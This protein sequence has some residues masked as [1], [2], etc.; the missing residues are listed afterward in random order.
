[1]AA[2]APRRQHGGDGNGYDNDKTKATAAA[3]TSSINYAVASAIALAVT[4]DL[5]Q[6]WELTVLSNMRS[7]FVY[8]MQILVPNWLNQLNRVFGV[9]CTI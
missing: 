2:I 6:T 5:C 7:L 3:V 8:M 4:Y 1:M 9:Y